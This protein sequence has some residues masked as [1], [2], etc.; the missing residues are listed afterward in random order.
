MLNL[1]R[2][3][4]KKDGGGEERVRLQE[5]GASERPRERE[6]KLVSESEGMR[7]GKEGERTTPSNLTLH[8][9]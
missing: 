7:V 8:R 9:L 5:D 3:Q 6:R 4:L 2:R 1:R